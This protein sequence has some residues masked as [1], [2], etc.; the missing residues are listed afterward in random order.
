[1]FIILDTWSLTLDIWHR[2]LTPDPWHLILDTW[3]YLTCYHLTP[4]NLTPDDWHP[5]TWYLI[6]AITWYWYTWPM[7]WHLTRYY[8]TWHL[9]YIAYSWLSLLRGTWHD[10]YTTTRHLVLLNSFIPCTHAL[11]TVTLVNSSHIGVRRSMLGVGMMKMYPTIMLA[12][13]RS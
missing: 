6:Y 13:G 3:W 5:I 7:L 4:K 10:Y 11:Y 9:Y 8:Y 1:M 2:Y 12:S